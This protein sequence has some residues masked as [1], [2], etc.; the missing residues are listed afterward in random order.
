MICAISPMHKWLGRVPAFTAA[1]S[2]TL[3]GLKET[4]TNINTMHAA[5]ANLVQS[6]FGVSE[7]GD[8]VPLSDTDGH[9]G[10]ATG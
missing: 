2:C 8:A 5:G 3:V 4:P 1:C 7:E 10:E 9:G 6:P